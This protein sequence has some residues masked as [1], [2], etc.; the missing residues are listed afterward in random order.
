MALQRCTVCSG[1]PPGM[2]C[3]AVQE[4]CRCLTSMIESGDLV[5]LKMLDVAR[6]NPI[7]S[8]L[9]GIYHHWHPGQ[10]HQLLYPPLVS[11]PCQSQRR[12][13]HERNS[14][15]C[16]DEDHWHAWTFTFVGGWVWFTPTRA[17]GLAHEH[18]PT[19]LCLLG[20]P[21]VTI[22]H[23]PV[24]AEVHNWPC[25]NSQINLT[26]LHRLRSSEQCSLPDQQVIKLLLNS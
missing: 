2:L 19:G 14:P 3:R 1:T 4:L 17:G 26:P 25:P 16:Q 7:S 13:H 20:V 9:K 15:L 12:L 8:P 10:N 5:N 11:W 24:M 21:K 22:L 23:F 18:T 6:R